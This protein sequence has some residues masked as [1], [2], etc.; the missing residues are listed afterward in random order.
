MAPVGRESVLVVR[1]RDE[2]LRAFLN[3]CRHRGA[4]LCTES[5][6]EL[7]GSLQCRYHAWTYDLEGRLVGAPNMRDDPD[8]RHD[9]HGLVAVG[10][11]VSHGLVFVSLADQPGQL[12]EQGEIDHPRLGN[13]DIEGLQL[14]GSLS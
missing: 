5:A 6:G 7:R 12:A 1:G 8:F 14:C 4:A 9:D 2:R 10:V 11:Q 3:V 13:Y